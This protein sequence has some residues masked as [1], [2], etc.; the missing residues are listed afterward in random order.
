M[1]RRLENG[2]TDDGADAAERNKAL[3]RR[4]LNEVIG[5]ANV[6]AADALCATT[7]TWHGV[8]IGDLPD[9]ATLKGLLGGFFAAFADIDM[10]V[11]DLVA[12]GDRVAAR[13]TWRGTHRGVFQGLPPTGQS[14]AVAGTGIFR[15]AG[16]KIVEE[17][18]QEDLLGLL[19]QLGAI[20]A[21]A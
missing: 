5:Q 16:G 7:L 10:T 18:W 15:L 3:V 11:E 6:A 19:R 20:P 9:L 13:Y 8:G 4:F 17:W 1:L 14:V 2:G 21:P 12:S